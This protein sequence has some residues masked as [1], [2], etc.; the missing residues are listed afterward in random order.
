MPKNASSSSSKSESNRSPDREKSGTR[1][2]FLVE[3]TLEM[4]DRR[5]KREQQG[6]R[7][8]GHKVHEKERILSNKTAG[9]EPV[10]SVKEHP[11]LG[12]NQRFDGVDE[13]LNPY[14]PDNPES[15]IEA[16][17]AEREQLRKKQ[18]LQ[19]RLELADRPGSAPRP[20]G[21]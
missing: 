11:L 8:L 1:V 20:M 19:H 10:A 7:A 2:S 21:P 16:E 12:Q 15:K 14:P 6:H 18:E 3:E 5:H 4:E 9:D 13:A 17:N